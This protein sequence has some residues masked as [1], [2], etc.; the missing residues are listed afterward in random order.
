MTSSSITF[1]KTLKKASKSFYT[2]S[3][4]LPQWVRNDVVTLYAWCRKIDDDID[5][6]H[7]KI[8][9]N[10]NWEKQRAQL[11]IIYD[12]SHAAT[13]RTHEVEA[14]ET[15]VHA[16]NIPKEFPLMLIEGQ[17]WDCEEKRYNTFEELT[18]YCVRVASSVGLMMCCLMRV[19]ADAYPT[20]SALGIAMQLTNIARDVGE[21]ARNGKIYLPIQWLK[22]EGITEQQL[23]AN[24]TVFTP[25]IG[26]TVKR[27]LA[28]ADYYYEEG[29]KGIPLL[30]IDC[31]L[32]ILSIS[33]IYQHIKDG[34]VANG[35]NSISYRAYTSS[36]KKII[37]VSQ[38]LWEMYRW[39]TPMHIHY[40]LLL[41]LLQVFF[42]PFVSALA[43]IDKLNK[44]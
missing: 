38:A 2:G 17:Q 33:H 1:E 40:L 14:F 7:N 26:R 11:D 8:V 9:R 41:L 28:K 20:A 44:K 25:A 19:G 32:A 27:L 24:P 42:K 18:E 10:R 43:Q 16:C 35:Y 6:A 29:N 12:S 36:S 15:L 39:A 21:D 22:E 4:L 23:L 34:I 30:P 37:L 5:E 3:L 13:A 31:R